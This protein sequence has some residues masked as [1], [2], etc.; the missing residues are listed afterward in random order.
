MNDCTD[1]PEIYLKRRRLAYDYFLQFPC[2]RINLRDYV[3]GPERLEFED[4]YG[5]DCLKCRAVAC[6]AG[7]LW[8]MPE[9]RDWAG[10]G[11]W[12]TNGVNDDG[13]LLEYRLLLEYL[14]QPPI[15]RDMEFNVFGMRK[16]VN[17]G[18]DAKNPA[19][20]DWELGRRRLEKLVREMEAQVGN[21][22]PS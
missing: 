21:K 18:P 6:V 20:S 4:S 8:T 16:T 3:A 13:L 17:D 7:T 22:M 5:L 2:E 9:F 12:G 10:I 15:S 19:I 11:I 1:T 14:G